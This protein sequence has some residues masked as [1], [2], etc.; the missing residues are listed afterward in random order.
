[1]I[2]KERE[3]KSIYS[4]GGALSTKA[5]LSAKTDSAP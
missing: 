3:S 4:K 5:H 2:F 1:V